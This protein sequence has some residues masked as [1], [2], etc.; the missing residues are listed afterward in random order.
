MTTARR[1]V[2]LAVLTVLPA[3]SQLVRYTDEIV[4][5]RT[6][7]SPVVTVPA[8]A[9]GFVG[10]VVGLPVDLIALP[11]TFPIYYI[12]REQDR[13]KADPLSTMLFPSFALWRM[14]TLIAVPFDAT[15]YIVVR[16]WQPPRTPNAQEQQAI[17][18]GF[19]RD[20]LRRYTVEPV[21]PT[22]S[23]DM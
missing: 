6:G 9:G 16:A 19:D 12:Q 8:T 4:D 2:A 14:G 22:T 13:V 20:T 1:L 17:E 18:D 23:A 5:E 21:Y 15:E 10:F 7:R 11:V 3:C